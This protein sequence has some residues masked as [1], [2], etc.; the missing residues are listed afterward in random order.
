MKYLIAGSE[1]RQQKETLNIVQLPIE[2]GK[3]IDTSNC[4]LCSRQ[5]SSVLK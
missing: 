2:K 5:Y 4:L 1:M 3:K